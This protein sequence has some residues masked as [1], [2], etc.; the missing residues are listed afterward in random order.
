MNTPDEDIVLKAMEDARRIL[1]E[2][3]AGQRDATL[4]VHRLLAVLDQVDVGHAL[5]R[6]KRRQNMRVVE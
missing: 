2:Y 5:D 4:T 1:V 6:I 3:I